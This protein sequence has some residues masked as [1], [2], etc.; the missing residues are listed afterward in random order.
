MLT[1]HRVVTLIDVLIGP[2]PRV[3]NPHAIVRGNRTVEK[4]PRFSVPIFLTELIERPLVVPPLQ[5]TAL[6]FGK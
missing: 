3:V 6:E 5:D 4:R 2:P 1:E